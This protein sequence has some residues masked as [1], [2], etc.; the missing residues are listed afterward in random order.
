MFYTLYYYTFHFFSL[1]NQIKA[2]HSSHTKKESAIQLSLTVLV[3][4]SDV[5]LNKPIKVFIPHCATVD[6][7][8]W[9]LKVKFELLHCF[10]VCDKHHRKCSLSKGLP[11]YFPLPVLVVVSSLVVD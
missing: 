6:N 10:F 9:N 3:G 1:F 5:M 2:E 4:P 11:W 7:A 8:I